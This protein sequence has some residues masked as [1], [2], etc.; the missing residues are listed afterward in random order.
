MVQ[1]HWKHLFLWKAPRVI[2]LTFVSR[3]FKTDLK[4]HD[5]RGNVP[6]A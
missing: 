6:A 1:E 2:F 5:K 4:W 3:C